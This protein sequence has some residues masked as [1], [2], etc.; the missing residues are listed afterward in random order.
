[1]GQMDILIRFWNQM[2]CIA[3]TRY[4]NSE[5]SGGAKEEQIFTCFEKGVQKFNLLKLIQISSDGPDTNFFSGLPYLNV[6][7]KLKRGYQT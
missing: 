2:K 1:M 7:T 3:E 6:A 5:F 4:F